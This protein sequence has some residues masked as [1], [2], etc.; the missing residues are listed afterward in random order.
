MTNDG[1][2]SH[3]GPF[4]HL[5]GKW[6]N[7]KLPNTDQ[8]DK[9]N[10]LS[11]NVMPLPQ[12]DSANGFILKNFTYYEELQFNGNNGVA[13]PA[14][15][16][17][18]GGDYTQNA[19]ALF[20]EQQVHFAEGPDVNNIVHVE[21]GAWLH[22]ETGPQNN[23]PY[24]LGGKINSVAD[25]PPQP[26]DMSIAKQISVPHGN[27]ILAL[28]S[29]SG[30]SGKPIIPDAALP[31]PTPAGLPT[32][33]YM[34]KLDSNDNYQNPQPDYTA[35]ANLPIQQAV[36]AI[37]P[38]SFISWTVTTAP[39][40]GGKGAV[41]NIPFEQRK[42]NVSEYTAS[43]W[44]LSTINEN[45]KYLIYT[46]NITLQMTINGTLYNFPHTTCNALTRQ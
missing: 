19:Y 27:S 23:G 40:S 43:Y 9:S 26:T 16:P 46:Q 21:N 29:F 34:T 13:S 39:L 36:D 2:V 5:I 33:S 38:E 44:L 32:E 18:R 8:G 14:Q 17:N 35:N 6:E 12:T 15:A 30:G 4:Q 7:E 42:A 3:L 41:T 37:K 28:G 25:I 10:P 1:P 11:Y 22:L 31:Y 45:N 24:N 20:Y